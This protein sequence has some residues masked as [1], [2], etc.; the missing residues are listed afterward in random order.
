MNLTIEK[1]DLFTA[2]DD[3]YLCHCISADF[4]LG[5]GIARTFADLGVRDELRKLYRTYYWN[6][7]GVCLFT[8]ATKWGELNLVTKNK[9][10]HKPTLETLSEALIHMRSLPGGLT[11]KI[12]MPKIGCGLDR[13]NWS[14]VEAL[15]REVFAETDVEILVCSLT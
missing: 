3:Y 15:I 14:D 5:A 7:H 6:G 10:Y 9:C 8:S 1:R 11:S 2:P 13:L 4:V 12:A